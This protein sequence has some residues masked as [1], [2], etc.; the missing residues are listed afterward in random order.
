MVINLLSSSTETA[1]KNILCFYYFKITMI[2]NY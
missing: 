1:Y 2:K